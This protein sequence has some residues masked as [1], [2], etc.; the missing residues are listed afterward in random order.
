MRAAQAAG[1]PVTARLT[2][3][4]EAARLLEV[5]KA[6]EA[7]RPGCMYELACLLIR[8]NPS[9][10]MPGPKP[11]TWPPSNTKYWLE[12]TGFTGTALDAKQGLRQVLG[13]PINTI[14]RFFEQLAEGPVALDAEKSWFDSHLK[15]QAHELLTRF[16]VNARVVSDAEGPPLSHVAHISD[17]FAGPTA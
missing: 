17:L 16:R 3:E 15:V 9:R 5:V 12:I 11:G 4:E 10:V 6:A 8:E 2:I 7:N 14:P 1:N 13:M